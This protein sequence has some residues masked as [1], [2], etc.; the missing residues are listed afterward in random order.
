MFEHLQQPAPSGAI[1][2]EH[3]REVFREKRDLDERIAALNAEA[4]VTADSD[5]RALIR[6]RVRA[7]EAHSEIL[8]ERLAA[9]V[10]A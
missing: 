7:M 3:Q 10:P 8:K 6:E 2:S 9:F 5:A 4:S 1:W